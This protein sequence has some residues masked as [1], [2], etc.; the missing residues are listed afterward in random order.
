MQ[1]VAEISPNQ[2]LAAMERKLAAVNALRILVEGPGVGTSNPINDP[3]DWVHRAFQTYRSGMPDNH[4]SSYELARLEH[5][6]IAALSAMNFD[7][8][9]KQLLIAFKAMESFHHDNQGQ[10]N[11]HINKKISPPERNRQSS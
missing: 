3:E 4:P 8:Q 10:S 7:N 5:E 11:R 2:W 9:G 1:T 6:I